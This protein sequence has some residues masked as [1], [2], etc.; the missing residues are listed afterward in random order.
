VSGEKKFFFWFLFFLFQQARAATTSGLVLFHEAMEKFGYWEPEESFGRFERAA[1]QGHE[2]SIWILSVVKGVEMEE[3]VLKET[4]AKTGEPWGWYFAGKFS[5]GKERFDFYRK[6]AEGG[7]SWGQVK[8]GYCFKYGRDFVQKDM[9]VYV[10]W[11]EKAAK[12]SNPWAMEV[13][14][15]W[16][17]NQGDDKEKAISYFRAAAQL[18]WKSAMFWLAK[19]LKK[20]EGCVKDLRQAV[21]WSAKKGGQFLFWALLGVAGR[22]LGSG[23]TEDLDC[24]FDQFCYILGWGLYWYQ[25]ESEDWNEQDDEDRAFGNRCLDFYCSCVELQ[26]ESIFLFLLYWNRTTGGIKG[27]GQM[28]GKIVWKGREENLVRGFDVRSE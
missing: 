8:Y 27:P 28:I 11:L 7:C 1:A 22:A 13:L 9:K 4:F 24:S 2:E 19:M 18:G 14:G 10:E 25:Y 26:Q 15:V 6:S 23:T 16:F 17:Q 12:Q 5:A 3:S 20:G 21:M